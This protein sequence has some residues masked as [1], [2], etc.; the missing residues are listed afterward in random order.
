MNNL[1]EE[2]SMDEQIADALAT[3]QEKTNGETY[4]RVARFLES[5]PTGE[6]CAAWSATVGDITD[7][8]PRWPWMHQQEESLSE[9]VA[10][11]IQQ[12]EKRGAV[13]ER[14]V[15]RLAA[16]AERLGFQL[17]AKGAV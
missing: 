10:L 2:I 17:V 3:L 6:L 11:L 1:H 4:C 15:E 5:K 7:R 14:E 9:A 13:N 12:I 8:D 16:L